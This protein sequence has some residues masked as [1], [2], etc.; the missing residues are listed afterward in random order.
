MISLDFFSLLM[1]LFVQFS[2]GWCSKNY[3]FLLLFFK[4]STVILIHKRLLWNH[5]CRLSR[6]QMNISFLDGRFLFADSVRSY[7][8]VSNYLWH[9]I[10]V[11]VVLYEVCTLSVRFWDLKRFYKRRIHWCTIWCR[12]NGNF[13]IGP[14]KFSV[15]VIY[16]WL[17]LNAQ[18]Y[19]IW[20]INSRCILFLFALNT[21]TTD[22]A[23]LNS[24]KFEYILHVLCCGFLVRIE[25]Q[26]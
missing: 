2:N 5:K 16:W 26:S 4:S 25:F 11:G 21:Y 10:F 22:T 12:F 7:W 18:S 23:D 6:D 13:L 9:V 3:V 24:V 19:T 1:I 15:R 20:S 14:I 8:K 17:F